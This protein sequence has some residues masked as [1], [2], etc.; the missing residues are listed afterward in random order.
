MSAKLTIGSDRDPS[1]TSSCT[2]DSGQSVKIIKGGALRHEFAAHR[3][4]SL[5]A[6]SPRSMF[7]GAQAWPACNAPCTC[8]TRDGPDRDGSP[9]KRTHR[10]HP[11]QGVGEKDLACDRQFSRLH[12]PNE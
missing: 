3:G 10:P 4:R 2:K 9:V 12:I 6:G 11:N 8:C 7:L 5:P 1:K